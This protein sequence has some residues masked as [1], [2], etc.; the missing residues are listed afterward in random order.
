MMDGN[1]LNSTWVKLEYLATWSIHDQF[2]IQ[3]KDQ[4]NNVNSQKRQSEFTIVSP[5]PRLRIPANGA[6][7]LSVWP[8]DNQIGIAHPNNSEK[9]LN[10]ETRQELSQSMEPVWYSEYAVSAIITHLTTRRS[11]SRWSVKAF[12]NWWTRWPNGQI[13]HI[14]TV[15]SMLVKNIRH[16]DK[17]YNKHKYN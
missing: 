3:I 12:M 17:C 15:K 14:C 13:F 2:I 1:S 7:G 16:V 5:I 9:W 10:R 6:S 8:E 4:R 11:E